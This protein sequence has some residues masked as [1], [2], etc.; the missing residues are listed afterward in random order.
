MKKLNSIIK[1]IQA[2]L[3]NVQEYQTGH[4]EIDDSLDDVIILSLEAKKELDKMYKK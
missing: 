4:E 3:E 2:I 1:N